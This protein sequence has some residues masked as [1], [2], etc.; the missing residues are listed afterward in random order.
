MTQP[1]GGELALLLFLKKKKSIE[2]LP[3]VA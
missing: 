3:R 1:L 2:E